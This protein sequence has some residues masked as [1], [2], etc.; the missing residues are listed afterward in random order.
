[1]KTNNLCPVCGNTE[2]A[3]SDK[4]RNRLACSRACNSALRSNKK[5]CAVCGR[6]FPCPP[7]NNVSTC[8]PECRK[9]LRAR[10]FAGKQDVYMQSL[11]NAHAG[12]DASPVCQP[13]ENNSHAKEWIIRS[14]SGKTY[15]CRNLL[16]FIRENAELFDGTAKQAWDGLTKIKYSMQGKRRRKS[17]QWKGWTLV[18]WGE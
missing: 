6:E 11:G 2:Q 17:A 5:T 10:V 14:P 13:D 16:H 8:S 1:M 15:E 7:A 12:Y 4:G 18:K 3:R 9:I